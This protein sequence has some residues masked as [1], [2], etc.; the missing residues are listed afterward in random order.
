MDSIFNYTDYRQFLADYYQYRKAEDAS[1]SYR[2]FLAKAGLKGPNFYREVVD[3]K[4][5]LSPASIEKFAKALEL[6]KR[7][8]EYFACLV[9][10]NQAKTAARKQ[11]YFEEL[12]GFVRRSPVQKIQK[13][14]Y[15]YFSKWYNV[16]IREYIYSHKF[17]G[18][19]ETL[20]EQIVPKISV[21]QAQKAVE[22]LEELGLIKK[23]KDGYYKVTDPIIST[24]TEING[25]G[26]YSYHKAML[27]NSKKALDTFKGDKRYFRAISGSFSEGAFQKIKL[28]LDNARKRILDIIAE[29]TNDKKVYHIGMQLFPMQRVNKKRGE[30][31]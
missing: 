14:Q 2:S 8:A 18:D 6:S 4:K 10:F 15:E 1:F 20:V 9:L 12:S 5:N 16:T 28:E 23:G 3:G 24:G 30:K 13:S 19:Y 31:K 27:D 26:A 17:K 29:D 25:I 7:E 21:R 11:K 22:L